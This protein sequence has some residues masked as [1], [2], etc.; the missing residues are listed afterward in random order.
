MMRNREI[1]QPDKILL[2]LLS[3]QRFTSEVL[4]AISKGHLKGH[5]KA[6]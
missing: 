1:A 6:N 3:F 5:F 4:D 2:H